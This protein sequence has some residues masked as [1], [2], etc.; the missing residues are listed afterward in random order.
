MQLTFIYSGST[1]AHR[2]TGNASSRTYVSSV[3]WGQA[4]HLSATM[5][6]F[7]KAMFL[8]I[9]PSPSMH[10]H[11]PR[12]LTG[13]CLLLLGL[14]ALLGCPPRLWPPGKEA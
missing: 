12:H 8:Y 5:H 4:L 9:H 2:G 3:F 7:H 1:V 11:T 10:T 14:T 13:L 6:L